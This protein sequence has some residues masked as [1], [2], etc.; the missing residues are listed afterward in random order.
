MT[1][2]YEWLIQNKMKMDIKLQKILLPRELKGEVH[3]Y[4]ASIK[5]NKEPEFGWGYSSDKKTALIKACAESVERCI[6]DH[7]QYDLLTTNGLAVHSTFNDAKHNSINELIERD[8][9]LS[10]YLTKT[11]FISFDNHAVKNNI[12]KPLKN[13][14]LKYGIELHLR[15]MSAPSGM[16]AFVCATYGKNCILKKYGLLLG[17]GCDRDENTAIERALLECAV[18]VFFY[19]STSIDDESITLD[20]FIRKG[21]QVSL[22]DHRSL[23]LNVNYMNHTKKLFSSEAQEKSVSYENINISGI[24]VNQLP[25]PE[26]MNGVPVVATHAFFHGSQNLFFQATTPEKI[27]LVRL[28]NFVGKALSFENI[29]TFP[30]P[31]S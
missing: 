8:S 29:Q 11:P 6:F 17:L 1:N 10:H 13:F 27:N 26:N 20:H 18:Q 3:F 19:L 2:L 4:K 31:L 25:I 22:S 12:Y 14:A 28:S 9:F 21:D 24:E 15:K 23:H 5:S 30:H 16:H 7:Y